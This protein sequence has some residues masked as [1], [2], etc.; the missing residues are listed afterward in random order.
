MSL[1]RVSKIAIL[2]SCPSRGPVHKGS[3]HDGHLSFQHIRGQFLL[4][5]RQMSYMAALG[6]SSTRM[7]QI[8]DCLSSF[9]VSQIPSSFAY[10]YKHKEAQTSL[11]RNMFYKK[12]F[13]YGSVLMFAQTLS[14]GAVAV[15]SRESSNTLDKQEVKKG[16]KWS[17]LVFV[18]LCSATRKLFANKDQGPFQ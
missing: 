8:A 5:D 17:K 11:G 2:C 3:T 6:A 10:N 16:Q 14:C 7:W 9:T 1:D 15:S 18:C 13:L 4:E 12:D